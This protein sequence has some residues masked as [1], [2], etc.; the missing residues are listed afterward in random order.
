MYLLVVCI[1][2]F[3]ENDEMSGFFSP[4]RPAPAP[5]T[6]KEGAKSTEAK[7]RMSIMGTF[8]YDKMCIRVYDIWCVNMF[9]V[10]IWHLK[11]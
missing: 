8:G 1:G 11:W 6:E 7:R 2:P 3:F 10:G 5:K 9:G 4:Q